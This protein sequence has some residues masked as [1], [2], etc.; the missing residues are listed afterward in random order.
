MED[1]LL[2]HTERDAA[3]S[4][5]ALAL[6]RSHI[7]QFRPSN[8]LG[9]LEEE[10]VDEGA[11]ISGEGWVS[12]RQELWI[13]DKSGLL[14]PF[15]GSPFLLL[16]LSYHH[17]TLSFDTLF[18]CST[19]RTQDP[20]YSGQLHQQSVLLLLYLVRH[21]V[22]S[23]LKLI[24]EG[25]DGAS[26]E[27]TDKE[28]GLANTVDAM[29]L[30]I[31]SSAIYP[32][33]SRSCDYE[34]ECREKYA[35][36]MTDISSSELAEHSDNSQSSSADKPSD[37]KLTNNSGRRVAI[38][39]VEEAAVLDR[40]RKLTIFY[41]L[42]SACIA[43]NCAEN[44]ERFPPRKG[45]D[46]QPRVSLRLLASWLGL[47]WIEMEALEIMVSCSVMTSIEA[48]ND[49]EEEGRATGTTW[50]KWKRNTL[51][52]AAALTGGT[53]MAIT[54][55]LAAPAIRQGLGALAPT[56]GSIIPAVGAGGF[57]AAATATGSAAGSMAVAA[58][59]GALT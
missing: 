37:N 36:A 19:L 46:A 59:S 45:Y 30:N 23:F 17:E 14:G 22:G 47:K 15:L 7:H 31:E 50:D 42:L 26:P 56:L 13:H 8:I 52:G 10:P 38:E 18:S 3:I 51:V 35:T 1:S 34:K 53:L 40:C 44:D 25:K 41:E 29:V 48:K 32:E 9:G 54:G 21:H 49:R 24:L 5:F 43:N 12:D 55:G 39:A 6:H 11:S 28:L 27:R 33:D 4:L 58:S 57:T 20:L 16:K 2:T